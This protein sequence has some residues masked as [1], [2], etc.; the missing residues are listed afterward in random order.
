[1]TVASVVTRNPV[2]WLLDGGVARQAEPQQRPSVLHGPLGRHRLRFSRT[3][4]EIEIGV[5]SKPNVSR[6]R[7]S[8][9]R[10]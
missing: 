10:R 7:R 4:T 8:M 9:Y 3:R 5:P 2:M 6:R 1:M